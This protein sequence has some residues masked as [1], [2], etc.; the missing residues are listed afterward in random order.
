MPWYLQLARVLWLLGRG[1]R[2]TSRNAREAYEA[3][4]KAKQGGK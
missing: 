3:E 2:R 4:K 1:V